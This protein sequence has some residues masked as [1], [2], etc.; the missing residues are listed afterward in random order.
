MHENQDITAPLVAKVLNMHYQTAWRRIAKL[1]GRKELTE[2]K[3][4]ISEFC[5]FYKYDVSM[6]L[7]V[8]KK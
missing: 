7:N 6:F 1:K 3:P 5:T 4:T 2:R 8:E